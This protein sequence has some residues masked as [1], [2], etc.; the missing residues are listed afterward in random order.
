MTKPPLTQ[1]EW[2]TRYVMRLAP[3]VGIELANAD[4]AAAYGADGDDIDLTI[5]PEDAADEEARLLLTD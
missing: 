1:A 2:K 3:Q 5:D 4:F